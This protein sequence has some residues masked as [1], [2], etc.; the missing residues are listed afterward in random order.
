MV[1]KEVVAAIISAVLTAYQKTAA[2]DVKKAVI[3][4]HA[5]L[6]ELQNFGVVPP[7]ARWS[8]AAE[9]ARL[10]VPPDRTPT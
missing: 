4:Y 9:L 1:E 3:T 5:C 6:T 7:E 2:D 10:N 8:A